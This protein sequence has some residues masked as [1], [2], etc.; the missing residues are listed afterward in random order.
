MT[1]KQKQSGVYMSYDED[2]SGPFK[3]A[4][5][6]SNKN[7]YV[8]WCSRAK[9]A[10]DRLIYPTLVVIKIKGKEWYYRGELLDI[11]HY[12]D[13]DNSDAI[14]FDLHH[15]PKSWRIKQDFE[16]IFYMRNLLQVSR[17][18]EIEDMGAPQRPVYFE[19]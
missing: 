6:I 4:A 16:T 12:A 8:I 15:R 5:Y 19:Y 3:E 1:M 2:K 13:I 18:V 17:P 10:R 14:I 9:V 7:D 11:K